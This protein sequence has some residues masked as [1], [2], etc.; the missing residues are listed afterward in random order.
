M[1]SL[2][3]FI[4]L[5]FMMFQAT[6]VRAQHDDR[7]R[8]VEVL[9]RDNSAGKSLL[10][11]FMF[12]FN[13]DAGTSSH[14]MSPLTMGFNVGYRFVP[15]FYVYA[16]AGGMFALNDKRADGVRTYMKSP[17]VGGG[18]GVNV[19][20]MGYT[21]VDVCGTVSTDI[22][23]ADFDN[24]S[25]DVTLLLRFGAGKFDIHL[26]VGYKHVTSH[27][28]AFDDYNGLIGTVGFGI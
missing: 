18:V 23:N 20:R 9:A 10:G 8:A 21:D 22:G 4:L 14:G 13:V 5:C 26:G 2:L 24:V 3:T 19:V 17:F 28:S 16:R 11:R 6:D 12:D 7:E 15:R 25:Y 1:K 27:S